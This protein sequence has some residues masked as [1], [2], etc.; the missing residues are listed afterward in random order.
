M[1]Q[2]PSSSALFGNSSTFGSG[3]GQTGTLSKFVPVTGTD[4]QQKS[5]V[6]QSI[7][8]K[9]FCITCMKE[10]ENK[11]LEELRWEDYQA[12]RKGQQQSSFGGPTQ[13][14]GIASTNSTLF[15]QTENKP[16]FGQTSTAFGQSNFGMPSQTT[17][18]NMFGKSS[19]AFGNTSTTNSFAFGGTPTTSIFGTNMAPKPFAATPNQPLFGSTQHQ[20]SNFG[21]NIFG[22]P[23]TSTTSNLFAKPT[24]QGFNM[25]QNTFQ[26]GTQPQIT[27][28]FQ[29]QKPNTGFNIFGQTNTTNSAFGPTQQ[30]SSFTPFNNFAKPN[31][32]N[33]AQMVAPPFMGK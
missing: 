30:Q 27:T 22:Q 7:N 16:V 13:P 32:S 11:S 2:G 21:T 31:Q 28:L 33:F 29:N 10:Y 24:Q 19:S 15:G 3:Q 12:N 1:F 25:G 26:F 8:T 6:V 9:H 14:F 4:S 20:Q 23:I 17:A 5:G 18:S